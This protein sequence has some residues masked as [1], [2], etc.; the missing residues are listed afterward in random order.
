M[1]TKDEEMQRVID[2]LERVERQNR[3]LVRGGL[4]F[5]LLCG[6]VLLMAQKPL[7]RNVEAQGFVL[8]DAAGKV[9]A[10]LHMTESGPEL[11]LY[12]AQGPG[13][14][15]RPGKSASLML[16]KDGPELLLWGP[17]TTGVRV[18]MLKD[19]PSLTLLGGEG[20]GDAF[21][22]AGEHPGMALSYGE[23]KADA[24]LALTKF[25]PSLDLSAGEGKADASLAARTMS[26]P[27][28]DLSGG[29]GKA[30]ARLASGLLGPSLDLS[31]GEGKADASL[32]VFESHPRLFLT[33]LEGFQV[34]VGNQ[35]LVT[36]T[37]GEKHQ[38][39][40]A[41]IHLFDPK[42]TTLWSAP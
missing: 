40:A 37:T 26:G 28:L 3:C 8:K 4:A 23:G 5:A 15:S 34:S 39:S 22:F 16:T 25:G 33:D 7:T 41:S 2:R 27:S 24:N 14:S 6:G 32:E 35:A 9:R 13:T 42:G 38:S 21:L 36:P 31:A 1:A 18:G 17:G 10:E 19:V 29:E 30:D 20:K 11:A 12:G